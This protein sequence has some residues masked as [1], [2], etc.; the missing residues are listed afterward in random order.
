[1]L[2]ESKKYD[3]VL[4]IL[5]LVVSVNIYNGMRRSIYERREEISVLAS[6]GAYSKHIQTLLSLTGLR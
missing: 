4:V 6:L 1:M 3:D 2:S 5:I